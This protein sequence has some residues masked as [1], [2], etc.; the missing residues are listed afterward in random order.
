M[1]RIGAT[2]SRREIHKRLGGGLQDYLPHVKGKVVCGC[3]R[4]DTNPGAPNVVLPGRG[5]KIEQSAATFR[6]QKNPIPIFI[7]QATNEWKYVGNFA[8]DSW[9]KDKKVIAS[10]EPVNRKGRVT[11]VLSL[12][13]CK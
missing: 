4:K 2:Y 12:K 1:F 10:Y 8:V 5:P 9:S 7:K 11:C 3:F 6:A 13:Q